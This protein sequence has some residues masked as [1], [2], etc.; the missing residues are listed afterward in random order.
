MHWF[1]YKKIYNNNNNNININHWYVW[2]GL[3]PEGHNSGRKSVDG[4]SALAGKIVGIEGFFL[5]LSFDGKLL[6]FLQS[7]RK[8]SELDSILDL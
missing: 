2:I 6:Y 8:E 7:F 1:Y 5:I 3:P 4:S